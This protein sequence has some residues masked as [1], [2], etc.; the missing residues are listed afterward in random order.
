MTFTFR[1]IPGLSSFCYIFFHLSFKIHVAC[2]IVHSVLAAGWFEYGESKHVFLYAVKCIKNTQAYFAERLNKAMKVRIILLS[3]NE[4]Y[5]LQ[6]NRDGK[7]TSHYK[8]SH[9]L[10]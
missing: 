10:Q 7:L 8:Q 5:W 2:S 9:G 1:C 4:L 3:V 6:S